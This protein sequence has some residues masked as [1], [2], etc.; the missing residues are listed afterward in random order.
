MS[1]IARHEDIVEGEII[2]VPAP[3]PFA[4]AEEASQ[5]MSDAFACLREG[6]DLI[7]NGH[8][9]LEVAEARQAW[10]ILGFD[11]WQD[12]VLAGVEQHLRTQIKPAYRQ[13]LTVDLRKR[14][15]VSS[16]ALAARLGV[17]HMTAQRDLVKARET[18]QLTEEAETV[19]GTDGVERAARSK[20]RPEFSKSWET[21]AIR[22]TKA[23]ASLHGKRDDDRYRAACP[24]LSVKW[25]ADLR[26]ALD[27]FADVLEDLDFDSERKM[28]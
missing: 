15:G 11:N 5:V 20:R 25:Q 4:S 16:R 14:Y 13:E 6:R 12:C 19:V 22:L 3:A 27:Q 1:D 2:D 7:Q 21:Q 26:R 18:G 10:K 8:D 17:S 9:L 23:L 24:D 28:P